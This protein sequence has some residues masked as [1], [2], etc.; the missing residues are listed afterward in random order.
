MEQ[1]FEIKYHRPYALKVYYS[2]YTVTIL[3]LPS[4]LC[5]LTNEESVKAESFLGSHR[6]R[7]KELCPGMYGFILESF[8]STLR[9]TCIISF[10]RNLMFFKCKI[11]KNQMASIY[12]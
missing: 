1:F 8:L 10:D 5:P 11:L 6:P 12:H 4:L 3:Q 9:N 7:V 2:S